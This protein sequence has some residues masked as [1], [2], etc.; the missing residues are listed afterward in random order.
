[1]TRT[2]CSTAASTRNRKLGFNSG[3]PPVR[4]STATPDADRK[5]T[6]CSCGTGGHLLGA[7]RTRVHVAVHAGLVAEVAEVD[8]Q[9]GEP[10]PAHRRKGSYW[11]AAGADRACRSPWRHS[12]HRT[13]RKRAATT[14]RCW[15]LTIDA[16]TL[17]LL[18]G[19]VAQLG[20]RS[21]RN[22]EVVGSTP[23]GS[24]NPRRG[25]R[26]DAHARRLSAPVAQQDRA[27]A[28]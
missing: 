14:G 19:A 6:T 27:S 10:A 21:V 4:S 9:R 7:L 24:T 18:S 15:R 20:E 16:S 13:C 17:R 8:L 28:S 5:S 23:I 22:A 1:M 12:R 11:S 3:A 26:P 2:P 25:S